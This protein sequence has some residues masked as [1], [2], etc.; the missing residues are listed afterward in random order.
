MQANDPYMSYLT[1]EQVIRRDL[2]AIQSGAN[3][4]GEAPNLAFV[5]TFL[6]QQHTCAETPDEK[7]GQLRSMITEILPEEQVQQCVISKSGSLGQVTFRVNTR[8]PSD[9]DYETV[10]QLNNKLNEQSRVEPNLPL[11]WFGFELALRKLMEQLKR[12]ILSLK[13][14]EFIGSKL[15]FDPP[16]LKACLNYLRQ[17][18]I[19]TFYDILPNTIFGSC[20]VILDKITELVTYSLELKKGDRPIS[21][22]RAKISSARHRFPGD[23]PVRSLFQ[24]LQQWSLCTGR[25]AEGSQ[26]AFHCHRG[27][28]GGIPN[29][30]RSGGW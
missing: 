14:C 21:R 10:R 30:L 28:A 18:H 20:Q 25:Y 1:N 12:Q 27:W 2:L 29:A 16:S 4:S 19:L 23:R 3:R 7:D 5:G 22:G 9:E 17:L 26:V 8:T 11:K 6:D 15:E 24:A 13:E